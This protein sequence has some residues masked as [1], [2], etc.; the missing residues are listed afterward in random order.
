[1]IGVDCLANVLQL[2]PYR[3]GLHRH[4][5]LIWM[6]GVALS[7]P[8]LWLAVVE[9][10]EMPASGRKYAH[11]RILA[12]WIVAQLTCALAQTQLGAIP[13]NPWLLGCDSLAFAAWI[14]MLLRR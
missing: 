5:Q 1:M 4:A 2:L 13:V 14:W 10:G 8:L 6:A 3:L 12:F 7:A 9:A 11:S